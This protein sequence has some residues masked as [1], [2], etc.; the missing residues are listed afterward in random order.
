MERIVVAITGASGAVY[1]VRLLQEVARAG[2]E[3]ACVVSR[4]ARAILADEVGWTLPPEPAARERYLAERC[5]VEAGRIRCYRNGDGHAPIAS[6]S[7]R[8][9]AMVVA[10]CSMAT[11]AALAAG[12]ADNLIRRA[13]DVTLK[14]GR[15][16]ILVPRE[17]PLSLIHLENLAR[18]ARA[19][20]EIVPPMPHFYT[21][22]E[23]VAEIVDQTV[24][25]VLDHLGI[26][27]DLVARW[28]GRRP[29]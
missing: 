26:D 28:Q 7:H 21:G 27:H 1:G 18:L 12:L 8:W 22:P 19:G 10:P 9:R 4:A 15:R 11:A 14:E 25:R 6:G 3:V 2:F 20:A 13:A 24:A 16:L 23:T 29:Q 5:G 17:S